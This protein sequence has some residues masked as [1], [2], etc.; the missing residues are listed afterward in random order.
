ME[1]DT[2]TGESQYVVQKNG[3]S[4]ERVVNAE[5]I[6][7]IED[8]IKCSICLDIL[9]KPYEC[10][11]CGSL[12]CED[13]INDWLKIKPS[14]P[15]KCSNFKISKAKVNTRKLLNLLVLRC[16][17]Y[18]EC[19]YQCEYWEMFEHETKCS[20]QKIKCP[21]IP[22]EYAGCFNDLKHHMIND[23][24]FLCYECEFCKSKIQKSFFEEHLSN[25]NKN[26]TFSIENCSKCGSC[27][28][29][30]RCICK[31]P[32]CL[33][34]IKIAKNVDCLKTCYLF[35][36]GLKTTSTIYN[37]SKYP[38]P[39][40]FEVKL[41]FT[42]VDW[43]RTG[44]TFDRKIVDEQV[45][46][47]CPPFALYGILEDLV[48]FYTQNSGW[49]NCF[50]KDKR[51]LKPGDYMTIIL[52]NGEMKFLVNE[53]DLGNIIKIDMINKEE[54]YLFIHCRNEKSRAEIIYINE[55]FN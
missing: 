47:N 44:I 48:Q 50:S 2:E 30:R 1:P 33:K 10:E 6:V 53:F 32:F 54:M 36:T 43:I 16:I 17:N 7:I 3:I 18:P 49:K 39:L 23:C 24:P 5:Q 12:F 37:I 20:F 28:C 19:D 8:L 26:K 38:L 42:S 27:E 22:C 25:H 51:P 35:H 4:R 46:M 14:C 21:N 11:I 45:D 34:C 40:N 41:L 52:K 31:K 9:S 29:P 15:M 13:C 55:I